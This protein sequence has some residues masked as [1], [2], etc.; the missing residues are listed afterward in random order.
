V[1]DIPLKLAEAYIEIG[2]DSTKFKRELGAVQR[3][4]QQ[5]TQQMQANMRVAGMAMAGVGAA[6][7]AGFAKAVVTFGQFEQVMANVGAVSNAT[8]QEMEKLTEFAKKMGETTIFTARESGKAMYF[9]A[10]AGFS[11]E[12]QMASTNAVMKLAA[13][14]QSDLSDTARLT[15]SSLKAFKLEASE[16]DRVVNVFAAAIGASQATLEKLSV[17]IPILSTK[18]NEMGYSVETSTAALSILID[19]GLDASRS[20]TGLRMSMNRLI[21]PTSKAKKAI[22]EMGLSMEELNPTTNKLVDIVRK[23]EDANMTAAQSIAI[24]GQRSE[25]MAILVSNGADALAE[26]EAEITGTTRAADMAS[27][28]LDTLAGKFDLLKSAVEGLQISIAEKLAPALEGMVISMT[29]IVNGLNQWTKAHPDLAKALIGF[30]VLLGGLVGTGGLLLLLA[31]SILAAKTAFIGLGVVLPGVA[32]GAIAVAGGI[33]LVVKEVTQFNKEISR[34]KHRF[35]NEQAIKGQGEAI[36][37]LY[38]KIGTLGEKTQ[39]VFG[40]TEQLKAASTGLSIV[41]KTLGDKILVTDKLFAEITATLGD[42]GGYI[43][44]AQAAAEITA[45]M[46]KAIGDASDEAEGL[47][48]ALAKLQDIKDPAFGEILLPSEQVAPQL[49]HTIVGEGRPSGAA[50]K[51]V[52]D[53]QFPDFGEILLPSEQVAPQLRSTIVGE[54]RPSAVAG[55]FSQAAI[56]ERQAFYDMIG[57]EDKDAAANLVKETKKAL[58][59][60]ESIQIKKAEDAAEIRVASMKKSLDE[61]GTFITN[62]T[63]AFKTRIST[64]FSDAFKNMIDPKHKTSWKTFWHDMGDIFIDEVTRMITSEAFRALKAFITGQEYSVAGQGIFGGGGILGTGGGDGAGLGSLAGGGGGGGATGMTSSGGTIAGMSVGNPLALT[65]ILSMA[66]GYGIAKGVGEEHP[67]AS[68]FLTPGLGGQ[69]GRVLAGG[70]IFPGFAEGGIVT[71]PTLAIV[72][73]RGPE[74]IRPLGQASMAGGN[75]YHLHLSHPDVKQI[76]REEMEYLFETKVADAEMSA[77][78][79][80]WVA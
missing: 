58:D 18:F 54:G 21:S 8:G 32:L 25:G 36:A 80:G 65:A 37:S 66:A 23:L 24:F 51:A 57:Q 59:A 68:F 74:E 39:T 47:A 61:M 29:E 49:R 69:L 26:M 31:P 1:I 52:Q 73:E 41:E 6:I 38:K 43:S 15:V 12:Q 11:A 40:S 5:K 22:A 67:L 10:S 76:T 64:A 50:R 16:A 33:A 63:D 28:Q 3:E 56:A 17:G 78:A 79:K 30:T 77:R 71:K 13:A 7:T 75:T 45:A 35:F 4:L 9:L 72:G 70:D 53:I 60:I 44:M 55:A 27:R 48:E 34:M 14:T 62:F 42:T 19:R 20:A 46:A 2:A